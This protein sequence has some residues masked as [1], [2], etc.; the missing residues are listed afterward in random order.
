MKKEQVLATVGMLP[1]EFHAEELIERI[2]FM[3]KVEKG[4][5]DAEE[6]HTITLVEAR[7]RMAGKWSR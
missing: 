1:D 3:A 6:D 2:I 7:E 4:L 5:R